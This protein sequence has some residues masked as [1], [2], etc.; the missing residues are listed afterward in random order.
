MNNSYQSRP[1]SSYPSP[2]EVKVFIGNQW[3]DD[4]YRIDYSIS[5]PKTPLYDYTSKYFKDVA[6]GHTIVQGT[7][8]INYRFPGYLQYAIKQK[9]LLIDPEVLRDLNNAADMF[10][11]MAEGDSSTKVKK[12]LMYKKLG[13][14]SNAKNVADVLYGEWTNGTS[15]WSENNGLRVSGVAATHENLPPFSVEVRYGGTEGLSTKIIEDCHLIGESQTISAAAIAGGDMS[16]SGMPIFE[17]YT[18][19]AKKVTDRIE[20]K[21][22]KLMKGT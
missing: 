6:G 17:L 18:F 20:Q 7:I 16:S 2:A 5:E 15:G 19:F 14:M 13:A 3:V 8:I 1:L 12:L 11:E 9:G 21:A 22:R 10:R 4:I